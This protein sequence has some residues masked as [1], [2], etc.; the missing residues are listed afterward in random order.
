[1]LDNFG[2]YNITEI[3]EASRST[4]Y[5]EQDIPTIDFVEMI[6]IYDYQ[7]Q[8]QEQ[9]KYKSVAGSFY[10]YGIKPEYEFLS[11]YLK[12]AQIFTSLVDPETN[13]I[14]KEYDDN[15]LIYALKQTDIPK[16]LLDDIKFHATGRYQKASHLDE[17]CKELKIRLK[18][19]TESNRKKNKKA[20]CYRGCDKSEAIYETTLYIVREDGMKGD[21]YFINKQLPLSTFFVKNMEEIMIYAKLNNKP[22]EELFTVVR[23]DKT[24]KVYKKNANQTVR[25]DMKDL[26][27]HLRNVQGFYPYTLSDILKL[28]SDLSDL[29]H[30]EITSLDFTDYNCKLITETDSSSEPKKKKEHLK[31]TSFYYADFEASTAGFHTPYCVSYCDRNGEIETIYDSDCVYKFLEALPDKSLTYFHNLGYDGRFLAKHGVSQMIR[32]GGKIMAMQLNFKGKI[33]HF[34]DSYA[35]ISKPLS[36]FP[37]MFKI[38]NIQKELYPYNYYIKDRINNNVGIIS[39]AGKYEVVPWKQEQYKLFNENIDKIPGCRLSETTFDMQLY[40]KFYCEQDVRILAIGHSKF[41][42]LCLEELE[43]DIDECITICSMANKY[44]TENVFKKIPELYSYSGVVRQYIQGCI[45]GG[46]CMTRQNKKWHVTENLYDYDA[47]SLYPSAINRLKL[48]TGKPT[49]IPDEY[50]G[51]SNYL[52]EHSMDEQQMEPTENKFISAF[53]V[54][55]EI[56]K[57]GKEL[58]F[59]IIMHKTKQG[60]RNENVCCEM[61]VDNYELED[62]IKFQQIEYIIKRGYYWTGNKSDLFSKEIKRIYDLRVQY[63]KQGNPLQEVLKLLMN[64]CY[65]KTIQKEIKTDFKY[66]KIKS[67]DKKG[68]VKYDADRYLCKNAK[69]IK[70]FYDIGNNIRCFEVNNSF[71]NYFVPNLI[72]VQ[73]LSM[74][75]RIMNEVMCLAEDLDIMIYYQDTDSMHI[76]VE[77]V[78]KLEEEYYKK[79]G[80]IL[81]GSDMGQFHPDFDSD[82]LT[83]DIQSVESYFL[84]KKA[85]CDKLASDTFGHWFNILTG[86]ADYDHHLRMKGIPNNL[87]D[88]EYEDPL[89][90][91]KHLYDGGEYNFNLLKLKPSF[92]MTKNMNIKTRTKF[93]RKISF[94]N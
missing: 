52:L 18:I 1:M 84:G 58:A 66:K 62:L 60:N 12:D 51:N 23:Y 11:Q 45:K 76:P 28:K 25:A 29:V 88:S 2:L 8:V 43:I 81:R 22:I 50:L 91:Y 92:E 73:I 32:K 70:Q 54:D 47:C 89:E 65:G 40:C 26:I 41:R 24:K 31:P 3:E 21:H 53:I 59:P 33:L 72:G 13:K 15:C 9:N 69:I 94:K 20:V 75:K 14:R 80:R 19:E 68:N 48:P 27:I 7:S 78:P 17:I 39:E 6:D 49:V 42:D 16:K 56:T 35:M 77:K 74:S 37:D 87:L 36:K 61:R 55:I 46:R 90:L 85:Y 57:V 67:K 34:R 44:F 86:E 30:Q 93:N 79:Y 38:D 4:Y 63:K 10:P 71:D 5:V 64:S 83:G 82:I